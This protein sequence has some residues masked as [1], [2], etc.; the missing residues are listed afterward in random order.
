MKIRRNLIQTCLLCALMLSVVV[1]AQDYVY[2]TNNDGT[3]TITEYIG[4]GGVVAIPGTINDLPVTSIGDWAFY[5]TAVT[6]VTISDSITNIG[7]GDF[8]DCESLTNV[9]IGNSVTDIGDWTFAFCS[10]L[11]SVNFRGNT[12]N[13]GGDDVFY[14][15]LATVY[16][17]SGNTNWGPTFDGHPAVLWNPPIPFN[18]TVNINNDTVTITRYTGSDGTATIPGMINFL[19]VTSI[20]DDAFYNFPSLT[21]VIIPSSVTTI[22]NWAFGL[23]TGL[24]SFTIPDNVISIGNQ[25]FAWC[26]GLTNFTIGNGVTSIG[27][28]AFDGCNSMTSITIGDNVASI[29]DD[30][31]LACGGL[32]SITIPGSVT[33]IGGAVFYFC[34]SLT[35]VIINEGATSIAGAEFRGCTSLTSIT[36]PNSVTSIGDYAFGECTSLP[37]IT[38]GTNITSIGSQAF[39]NCSSLTNITIPSSV[40]SIGSIAFQNCPSLTSITVDPLN[41]VYSSAD[42]VLFDNS[43]TTLIECPGGKAGDC[44]LPESVITISDQAFYNCINVNSVTFPNSVTYIGD[45]A[46]WNCG[47][48]TNVVFGENLGGIGWQAFAFCVYLK[49]VYFTG[50]APWL[51]PILGGR[52]FIFDNN[53]T[54][55]HLPET[56]GWNAFSADSGLPTALWLLPNP[57]ILNNGPSFGI[58]TNG[59]GFT[60][61]WATNISVIVEACIDLANPV[62]S[63][64]ATNSFSG[65]LSQFNDPQWTNFPNRF[66]RLRS[67]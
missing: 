27:A 61:S 41:P 13:L 16:Y 9:T 24:T 36:I 23:D 54:A 58:Q 49:G 28:W 52:T 39:Y 55:Y 51:S 37:S 31:F 26:S 8:F 14:G 62:W 56:T 45:F 38:I 4:S 30:A 20:G 32:V 5:A 43:Q 18:Y 12:P 57:R 22:G 48:L 53:A 7:D 44:K 42:G 17:L 2:T 50:N 33:N 40:T 19:P 60:I 67:P 66:Y 3:L 15:N 59:F 6:S 64:V 25:A 47:S 34:T 65:G 11:M 29:A 10:R 1:Q 63:P 21:N 35:N 46:F